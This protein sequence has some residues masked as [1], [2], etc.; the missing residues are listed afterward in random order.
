MGA[1]QIYLQSW[2]MERSVL[3]GRF[4]FLIL[5]FFFCKGQSAYSEVVMLT[6][7]DLFL[8]IGRYA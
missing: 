7:V 5:I 4:E 1:G 3:Q 8:S 2:A 6:E